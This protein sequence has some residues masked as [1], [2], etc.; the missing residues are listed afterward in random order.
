[1]S[2]AEKNT[3]SGAS[4]RQYA[5]T[6]PPGAK[7]SLSSLTN[8]QEKKV[9]EWMSATYEQA[10]SLPLV[11]DALWRQ[12]RPRT[13][14]DLERLFRAFSGSML[15]TAIQS[16]ESPREETEQLR[17]QVEALKSRV[18]QERRTAARETQRYD[19]L[20]VELGAL[21]TTL[22]RMLD[23]LK[24]RD[25]TNDV[26]TSALVAKD[27][28][29]LRLAESYEGEV[30]HVS[31]DSVVVVFDVRGDLIE[32]TYVREQFLD[33]QLPEKGDRLAAYI[34]IAK[35]PP[36][37]EVLG[38]HD[39]DSDDVDDAGRRWKNAVSLPLTL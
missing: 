12:H 14:A 18:L 26:L 37:L 31:D 27:N 21:R 25:E 30:I 7:A 9:A 11:I 19:Q 38:G 17:S 1:M 23:R 10:Q 16:T 34:H 35:L 4:R 33:G 39:E 32:Q 20:A 5:V 3:S 24:Q 28:G 13:H 8:W 22:D 29:R 36:E 15:Q 2:T 6:L